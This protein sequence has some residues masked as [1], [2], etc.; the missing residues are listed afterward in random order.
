M[1]AYWVVWC[2][3]TSAPC[4][5]V[6][7]RLRPLK[8]HAILCNHGHSEDAPSPPS[9]WTSEAVYWQSYQFLYV[10]AIYSAKT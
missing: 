3:L 10:M 6:G 4:R 9:N 7:N 8:I 2:I 5:M 1:M